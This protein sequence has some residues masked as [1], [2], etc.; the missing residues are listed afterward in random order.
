MHAFIQ[1]KQNEKNTRSNQF[2][3]QE[4][5]LKT[6][7]P[8]SYQNNVSQS[9]EK[10]GYIKPIQLKLDSEGNITRK[11]SKQN[12]TG[13]PSHLKEEFEKK[14]GFS[15][16]NVRV[17][18]H[19][20]KPAQLDAL[21]YTQG[22]SVYIGPGQEEHLKH[23][24]GHVVQ[25]K[26]GIV[27]PTTMINQLPV[28]MDS[29]LETQADTFLEQNP[30]ISNQ[31]NEYNKEFEQN[32]STIQGHFALWVKDK[33][34][35][36]I[37]WNKEAN[38]LPTYTG[39]NKFIIAYLLML[40]NTQNTYGFNM[41]LGDHYDESAEFFDC[42]EVQEL[43]KILE[44]ICSHY[45]K[46]GIPYSNRIG[47]PY[48]DDAFGTG[49]IADLKQVMLTTN[50]L[51]IPLEDATIIDNLFGTDAPPVSAVYISGAPN[52]PPDILPDTPLDA[53]IDLR[54]VRGANKDNA[55]D[56]TPSPDQ[57]HRRRAWVER[58]RRECAIILTAITQDMPLLG[59]CGGAWRVALVC[60]STLN[61]VFDHSFRF[62]KLHIARH[63]ATFIKGTR[64]YDMMQMPKENVDSD[65]TIEVNSAHWLQITEPSAPKHNLRFIVSAR[66][67]R[68]G[69]I[70]AFEGRG[71]RTFPVL[72]IQ[73][74]FEYAGT[75]DRLP[76]FTLS[77]ESIQRAKTFMENFGYMSIYNH[78]LK[79]ASPTPP[80][81]IKQVEA[82]HVKFDP[83]RTDIEGGG[84]CLW[85]CLEKYGIDPSI[86]Q[87]IP[88]YNNWVNI[89]EVKS[90]IEEINKITKDGYQL[91]IYE[92]VYTD[93]IQNGLGYA[94]ERKFET[95]IPGQNDKNIPII[96]GLLHIKGIPEGHYIPPSSIR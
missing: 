89:D 88:G 53:K 55:G 75:A 83:D 94:I 40:G 91:T 20:E 37:D 67:P 6:Y 10:Y 21:A 84:K 11:S 54:K 27:K 65:I 33:Y 19:S 30:I 57:P 70:E 47:I 69:V 74:H 62:D 24:L 46:K 72:G 15:F 2:Q 52:T 71:P 45:E 90:K 4:Q 61:T 73:S 76:D 29:Q 5:P 44:I 35:K 23:E 59:M 43:I 3:I 7:I 63:P 1:E 31:S 50:T 93:S 42:A 14:S 9:N 85:Q 79:H 66:N 26:Q 77:P 28:N 86:L 48:R 51:A 18:Y 22:N 58:H 13:I 80:L 60:G 16:D 17:Y 32:Q 87:T 49:I 25:Q 81:S 39:G 92:L 82:E 96:L 68:D 78:A 12:T 34:G 38:L 36:K 56:H 41:S 95:L 8:R 64:I